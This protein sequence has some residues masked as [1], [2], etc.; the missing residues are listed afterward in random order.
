MKITF[1]LPCVGLCGGVRVVFEY[2]NRLHERGHDVSVV[3]PLIPM[4]YSAKWYDIKKHIG[5]IIRTIM[6]FYR[7]SNSNWFKLKAN[8][9]RVPILSTKYISNS[10]IIVATWWETAYYVS[11]SKKGEKFYLIQHYE[12]WGGPKEKVDKT[13]KLGLHNIVVSSWLKSTIENLGTRVEAVILNGVNFSK[14][15]SEYIERNNNEIRI[16]MPYRREKWKGVEDGLKAI[17]I[18]KKVYKNIRLVMFGPKPR[19]GEL[20]P[21]V[22]FHL[23][24]TDDELRK[25]YNSCDIFVFPS[26]CEGFGLPPMEAMAC[27]VPVITTNVGAVP[28]YTIPGKTALVCQ[29]GDIIALSKYIIELIEDEQ[30]RKRIAKKGY[31]YIKQFTWDKSTDQLERIFKE[32]VDI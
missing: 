29:P 25:L 22:E 27:R 10:D 8:L 5:R 1:V 18:V 20:P 14:F 28:D 6:N 32:Y 16:L 23:L 21:D 9:M 26:R 19:K 3:Y 24:P 17:E 15:Y 7:G 4:E 2:A 12:V 11:K 31:Q 30:K 13:Y